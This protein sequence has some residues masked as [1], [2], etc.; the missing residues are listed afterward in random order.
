V[1]PVESWPLYAKSVRRDLI[2][3]QKRPNIEVM[4]P[5]RSYGVEFIEEED[6]GLNEE[7]K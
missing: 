3:R 6:A 7:T 5:L 2:K 1:T 4:R